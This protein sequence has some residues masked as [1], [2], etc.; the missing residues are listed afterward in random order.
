M[1]FTLMFTNCILHLLESIFACCT[2]SLKYYCK[3][4]C[5]NNI[6]YLQLS[7]IIIAIKYNFYYLTELI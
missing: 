5:Q 3:I 1:Y 2:I 4:N 7:V 6:R